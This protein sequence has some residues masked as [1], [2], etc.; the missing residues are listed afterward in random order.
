M[1]VI[2]FER[3]NHI[4]CT[5]P[6]LSPSSCHHRDRK[7]KGFL[8][9]IWEGKCLFLAE[10]WPLQGRVCE[11]FLTVCHV[12]KNLRQNMEQLYGVRW[13]AI[14]KKEKPTSI[15]IEVDPTGQLWPG[16]NLATFACLLSHFSRANSVRP[17]RRQRT[18]LPCPWDSPGK[19]T[20]V[21]CHFLLQ[22]MKVKSEREVAQSCPTLHDPMDHSLPGSSVHGI[23]QAR[24]LEWG[25]IALST[26]LTII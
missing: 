3:A 5:S 17:H 18:R 8:T 1:L 24:V 7:C 15:T 16:G 26:L 6:Q 4:L 12:V 2:E 13:S 21:G 9:I 20:G 22:C 25:A 23:F 11:E 19:N 14:L 10:T